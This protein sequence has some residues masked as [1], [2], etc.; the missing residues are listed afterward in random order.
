VISTGDRAPS[1]NMVLS[2][3]PPAFGSGG[4]IYYALHT[5]EGHELY[6]TNGERQVLLLSNGDRLANDPRRVADIMMGLTTEH[7]DGEG[8]LAFAAALDDDSGA[9]LLGVP[10]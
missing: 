4:E 1:G 6:A 2:M 7:V 8:R 9:I 5:R 3:S 10:A